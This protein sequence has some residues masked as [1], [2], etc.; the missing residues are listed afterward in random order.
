MLRGAKRK[1]FD[2]TLV[3]IPKRLA[4][5]WSNQAIPRAAGPSTP[6]GGESLREQRGEAL[7]PL[8]HRLVGEHEAAFQKHLGEVRQAQFIA[9]VPQDDEQHDLRGV[10][11]EVG[12]NCW[13]CPCVR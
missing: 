9:G 8:A 5:P 12:G 2:T 13:V 4:E 10:F 11:E 7:L 3:I 1:V 6:L